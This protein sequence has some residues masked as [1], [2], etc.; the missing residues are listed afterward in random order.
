MLMLRLHYKT[1]IPGCGGGGELCVLAS[2]FMGHNVKHD[3]ALITLS[4]ALFYSILK[5]IMELTFTK[6]TQGRELINEMPTELLGLKEIYIK[7]VH[8]DELI[9]WPQ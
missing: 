5:K 8:D 9:L 3:N 6:C 1:S 7:S 2:L 4:S